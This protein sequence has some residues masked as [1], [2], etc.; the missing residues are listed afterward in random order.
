MQAIACLLKESKQS[1]APGY[2]D[3]SNAL[4][5]ERD[6]CTCRRTCG[7]AR[8]TKTGPGN[9]CWPSQFHRRYHTVEDTIR[10]EALSLFFP[11][12]AEPR[13]APT[14][15][16]VNNVVERVFVK[17]KEGKEDQYIM[18]IYNN[19]GMSEKV[20]FEHTIL[21]QLA[22]QPLSIQVP[23]TLP[24]KNGRPHELLSNGAECCVFYVIPGELAKTTSPKE[25]GRAT[26]E[27][28]SAMGKLKIDMEAP[29][30]PYFEL[31]KVHHAINEELFYQEMAKP[32][33]DVAREPIDYLVGDR[34]SGLLDFEF[35]S[36]D[37]RAMELAVALSKCGY[38]MHGQL[39]DLEAECIPDL[40]NLRIASNA[41]YFTGRAVG[42]EDSIEALTSRAGQ[43][44]KR[45]RWVNAN[46]EKLVGAIKDK[47]AAIA[48]SKTTA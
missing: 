25:V 40:I 7:R 13:V 29:I 1:A 4:R 8:R 21:A 47:M 43:Y 42:K 12:E 18:R 22:P 48:K 27:L 23:R 17:N 2:P 44:A 36:Y 6:R 30:A 3:P 24:S 15:G 39:S 28:N 34:V 11:P 16:G 10:N 41:V 33:L 5:A 19:G 26:G 20:V 9:L 45:V 37:W 35:C 31:F 38:A 32:E 46:R 14:T